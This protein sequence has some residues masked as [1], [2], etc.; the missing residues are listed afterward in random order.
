MLGDVAPSIDAAP[1]VCAGEGTPC[2]DLNICTE[3]SMCISGACVGT[4]AGACTVADFQDEF[5]LAQG[6]LGWFYGAWNRSAD[7]DTS[8]DP[9]ADFEMFAQF[10]GELWRPADFE[11][12][13]P[14]FTWAYISWWGGHPGSFP[15]ERYATRRWVSDVVGHA[16]AIVHLRKSDPTGGDGVGML[17]YVEDTLV[18]SRDIEFDDAV[19]FTESV[20]IELVIGTRVDVMLTFRGDDGTDTSDVDILIV[21]R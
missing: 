9:N 12:T 18:F 2:D 7:L 19:G 21:S 1:V 4:P 14:T 5:S 20:P 10:P 3:T 16:N 17:V 15:Q 8:Y 13:G 6:D 11:E